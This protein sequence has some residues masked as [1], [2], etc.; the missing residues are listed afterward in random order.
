[1]RVKQEPGLRREAFIRAATELFMEKGYEAVSVRAVLHA[2]GDKT[3][4][5]SVFYYYFASK[6]ALYQSCV[7]TAAQRY[8]YEMQ[9]GFDS[10]GKSLSEQMVFL[11]S[12]LENSLRKDP[13]LFLSD[14]PLPNRLFILDVREQVTDAVA[15]MWSDYLE[16]TGFCTGLEAQEL[17][18]F[19][20]GGIGEMIYRYMLENDRSEAAVSAVMASV[21]RLVLTAVGCPDE[22]K[23]QLID[24]WKQHGKAAAN[25]GIEGTD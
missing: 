8:L 5:P 25:G 17:G 23:L 11:A 19:L 15:G 9:N 21:I 12:K 3:A 1:M 16:K 14:S 7:Q 6:A 4:S 20:A 22:Q 2:V 10:D 13:N 18:C 24:V